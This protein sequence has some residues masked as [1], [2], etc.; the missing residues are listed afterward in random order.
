M[1]ICNC[2][3][4]SELCLSIAD[5]TTLSCRAAYVTHADRD[6]L[7]DESGYAEEHSGQQ[8]S[9]ADVNALRCGATDDACVDRDWLRDGHESRRSIPA[10]ERPCALGMIAE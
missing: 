6:W 3:Q 9:I 10:G 2:G 4:S 7:Q 5:Y 8:L 1:C